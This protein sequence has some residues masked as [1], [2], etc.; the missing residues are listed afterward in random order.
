MYCTCDVTI[1][2]AGAIVVVWISKYYCVCVCVVR[3]AMCMRHTVVRYAM[4]MR[5]TFVRYA[6]R[7]RHNV[8]CR[9]P[10][11]KIFFHIISLTAQF[12]TKKLI[13]TTILSET[14]LVLRRV[15]RDVI[16]TVQWVFMYSIG[17]YC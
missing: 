5:H 16:T 9:L 17:Y 6:M 11:S 7:M 8:V 3:Y 13:S 2:N 1:R 10:R 4:R 15:Q 14:F 12:A